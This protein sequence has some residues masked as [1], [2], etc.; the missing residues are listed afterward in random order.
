MT[1][2]TDHSAILLGLLQRGVDDSAA[3]HQVLL[4]TWDRLLRLTRKMLRRY[5]H[6]HRWEQTEDVFQAAAMKLFSSLSVVKPNNPRAFL[7]LAATQIRRTLID[8]AR[9]HFG[10]LGAAAHHQSDP[11]LAEAKNDAPARSEGVQAPETLEE[12][13]DF[14]EAIDKLPVD[15]REV[16]SL[17]WYHGMT[18]DEIARVLNFSVA[19]VQRKWYAAQLRIH[20]ALHGDLPH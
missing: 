8:L 19:T 3:Y 10:P 7:G 16:F 4:H 9:H 14:H 11:I 13:A 12:W 17:R 6:V 20:D 15:L 18:Q 1:S 2:I 5:P